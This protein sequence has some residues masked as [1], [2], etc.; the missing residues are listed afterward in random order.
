MRH[1]QQAVVKEIKLQ[2]KIQA[3]A[4]GL[5]RLSLYKEKVG[6]P[7]V[8]GAELKQFTSEEN[9][10]EEA[11]VIKWEP[12]MEAEQGYWKWTRSRGDSTI[13]NKIKADDHDQLH[14]RQLEDTFNDT[15]AQALKKS[16]HEGR[17]A[18]L[19]ELKRKA[20]KVK[21]Q[22][23]KSSSSDDDSNVPDDG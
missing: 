4:V 5:M 16:R 3:T 21:K 1:R 7:K 22:T 23:A 12:W 18:T 2:E 15:A 19:E 9:V 6:D 13:L 8:T 17:V 10:E 14:K 11:V 20:E